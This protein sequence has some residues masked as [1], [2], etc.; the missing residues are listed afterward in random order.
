[1]TSFFK[2]K[3][4]SF[5]VFGLS[6]LGL[7]FVVIVYP[8]VSKITEASQRYQL[9]RETLAS[10][11]KKDSLAK[12]LEK[13]FQQKQSSLSSVD[14]I[15]LAP[16]ET[17]GFISTLE[18]IAKETGNLFEIKTASPSTLSAEKEPFL[19]LRVILRGDFA[20]LLHF[21]AKL[22]NSPY[23]PYRLIDFAGLLHFVAKL[24]N[25]PYP[26]YR[27]I[28]IDNLNIRRLTETSLNYLDAS[29]E[30]GDLETG[31][32]IKIYVKPLTK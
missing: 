2:K 14:G 12:E 6:V 24:E 17:V 9:N 31:I 15:L 5:I 26:P 7:V 13:S 22:E 1:M 11:D 28:E 10:F 23:P 18:A 3:I 20:E 21:V 27:L 8:L 16:D 19:S 4:I 25:G 32:E 30:E 29:L